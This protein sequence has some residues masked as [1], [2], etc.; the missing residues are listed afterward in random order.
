M[1]SSSYGIICGAVNLSGGVTMYGRPKGV[2]IFVEHVD[3]ESM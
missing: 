3:L 2:A 1:G